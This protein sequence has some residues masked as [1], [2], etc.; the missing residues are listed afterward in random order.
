MGDNY[1]NPLIYQPGRECAATWVCKWDTWPSYLHR[2]LRGT[3]T[4]KSKNQTDL[5]PD[6][7]PREA[8][9]HQTLWLVATCCLKLDIWNYLPGEIHCPSWSGSP[10]IS[11]LS[12][13]PCNVRRIGRDYTVSPPNRLPYTRVRFPVLL[14][15][16]QHWLTYTLCSLFLSR[17]ERLCR[18]C[19]HFQ[20]RTF[21]C[22]F[23]S[24]FLYYMLACLETSLSCSIVVYKGKQE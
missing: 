19:V 10:W 24:I 23:V 9:W 8:V 20:L 1:A 14:W 3:W 7:C 13:H 4:Q 22:F 17:L 21:V 6:S 18:L 15:D 11:A 5:I 12:W 2:L 16:V